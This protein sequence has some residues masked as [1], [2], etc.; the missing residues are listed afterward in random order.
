MKILTALF[1]VFTTGPGDMGYPSTAQLPDGKLVTV[2]YAE[3]FPLLDSYHMGAVG[4][5]TL[6]TDK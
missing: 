1:L 5:T 3:K 2:F 6:A 4:W